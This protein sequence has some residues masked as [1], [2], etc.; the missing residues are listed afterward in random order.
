MK[1]NTPLLF[2]NRHINTI[3]G[4]NGPRK[5][6][7]GK[8]AAL[9][10]AQSQEVLLECRA[11]VKLHGLY[12]P[13]T[14]QTRGLAVLLHG[15][16]G[17]AWSTYLQSLA[18]RLYDEGYG[19]FR[20]H[21]R[22]HGPSHHLNH[23]PFLAI[24][25]DEILDAMEVISARFLHEKTAL[26]GFSLGAN[27]AARVA[28]NIGERPIRL[29]QVIAISPPIDP[30]VAAEAIQSYSIYNRYFIAKWQRSFQRK[31]DLFDDYKS[32]VDLLRHTD[33]VAMHE[34]FIPRFSNHPSAS[35]Y[36]RAYA[37]SEA[38]I[39][40]MDAPCHLIMVEDDPVIPV[41]TVRHLPQR[42]G[43]TSEIVSHGGHCGFVDGYR[44]TSW[45]DLRVLECLRQ[46]G[47]SVHK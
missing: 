24:R 6:L 44:M 41:E 42:T 29:D 5:W 19:I 34:D 45:I 27:M 18:A 15:W 14:G 47:F 12:T 3:F 23:D 20:L 8:R 37:L 9:L 35:S 22:D 2:R 4:N 11:G 33:I 28:A 30:E 39:Q 32:H 46:I 13:A 40:R 43:L 7:V 36:F 1:P 26:I 17:T 38:N 25:L 16:E 31:I 21:M 10:N